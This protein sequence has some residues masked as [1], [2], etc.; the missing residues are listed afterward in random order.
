LTDGLG[1]CKI[2]ALAV[3]SSRILWRQPLELNR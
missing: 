1:A 2:N 3:S